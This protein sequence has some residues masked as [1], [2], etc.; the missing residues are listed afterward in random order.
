MTK[1][2]YKAIMMRSR[3]R[4]KLLNFK[5]ADDLIDNIIE[6]F[7]DHPSI[8]NINQKAFT[9]NTFSFPKCIRR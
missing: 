8:L 5:T 1:E 4:N 9:P 2:L 6:K 3:S 7:N